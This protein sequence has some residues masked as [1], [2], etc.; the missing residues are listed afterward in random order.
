MVLWDV[1]NPERIL[2]AA[3]PPPAT[4]PTSPHADRG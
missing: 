2:A 3:A 1:L 4:L